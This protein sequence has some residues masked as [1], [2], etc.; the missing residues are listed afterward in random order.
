MAY[1]LQSGMNNAI[2]I[3]KI[4]IFDFSVCFSLTEEQSGAKMIQ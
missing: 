2:Y 4:C 3:W 1:I